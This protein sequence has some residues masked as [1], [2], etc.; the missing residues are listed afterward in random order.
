MGRNHDG[1]MIV[2]TELDSVSGPFSKETVHRFPSVH[3]IITMRP[4]R[5]WEERPAIPTVLYQLI[6]VLVVCAVI[7]G[8]R[9]WR[10]RYH[11]TRQKL[12]HG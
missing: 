8:Y 11:Y 10:R 1:W 4:D 9:I 7:I 3:G 2:D 6:M 12:Q 5:A